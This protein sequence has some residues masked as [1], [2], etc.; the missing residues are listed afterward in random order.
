MRHF[1]HLELSFLELL[2]SVWSTTLYTLADGR[3]RFL[4]PE[5]VS[6]QFFSIYLPILYFINSYFFIS[7]N[8]FTRDWNRMR[9]NLGIYYIL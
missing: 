8:S 6:I 5:D 7:Q 3:E 1:F 4:T 2:I 9:I